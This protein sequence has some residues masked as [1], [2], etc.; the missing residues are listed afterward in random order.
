MTIEHKCRD[1]LNQFLYNRLVGVYSMYFRT[2][3]P[4]KLFIFTSIS[5]NYIYNRFKALLYD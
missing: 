1:G 4:F 2:S 5:F 3:I